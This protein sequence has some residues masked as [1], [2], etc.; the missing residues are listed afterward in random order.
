MEEKDNIEDIYRK[1]FTGFEPPPPGQA[2]EKVKA[3]LHPAELDKSKFS[4]LKER[5]SVFSRSPNLYPL[6]ATAAMVLLLIMIWFSYSHKHNISGHAYAGETRISRGTAFLFQVY[7]KAKPYDTVI[8]IQTA[9]VDNNGYYRFS[10]IIHGNYFLRVNPL[11][12]TDITKNFMP[13]FYN[14]D[15]ASS[16]AVIIKVDNDDPTVDIHLLPK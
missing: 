9:P 8:L 3:E 10:G 16:E 13:S 12:G 4:S 2:W 11:P 1:A 5:F 6:L 15:S 14:Q 7:D